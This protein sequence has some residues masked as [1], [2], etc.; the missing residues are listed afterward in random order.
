M[1]RVCTGKIRTETESRNEALTG[2]AL[3]G[4]EGL[5]GLD[6]GG[7]ARLLEAGAGLLLEGGV[8]A[9]TGEVRP[10]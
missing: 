1:E 6:F 3:L 10:V 9:D 7:R 2:T 5:G 4:L 8:G